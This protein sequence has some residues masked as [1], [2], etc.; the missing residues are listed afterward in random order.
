MPA[1]RAARLAT[2]AVLAV[3]LQELPPASSAAIVDRQTRY[4]TPHM[5][6][7]ECGNLD[8]VRLLVDAGCATDA[9][10]SRGGKTGLELAIGRQRSAVEGWL[11][12]RAADGHEALRRE[13]VRWSMR[14]KVRSQRRDDFEVAADRLTFWE[15]VAYE[16]WRR[17]GGGAYGDLYGVP[18]F[19][20]LQLDDVVRD[21]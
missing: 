13:R 9:T 8:A 16:F 4:G 21:V 14:P 12:Q 15:L 6:A 19:P 5:L 2:A 7:C 17:L 11:W 10:E 20:H 1:H 3:L 18:A